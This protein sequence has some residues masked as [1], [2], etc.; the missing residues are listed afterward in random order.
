MSEPS[1]C[2]ASHPDSGITQSS[3]NLPMT[4]P[5]NKFTAPQ[6]TPTTFNSFKD[7]FT[8]TPTKVAKKEKKGKMPDI[9]TTGALEDE[10]RVA[11]LGYKQEVRGFTAPL[12][13]PS[14]QPN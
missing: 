7:I 11:K 3:R 6:F 2:A 14:F 5:K 1:L 13:L 8:P 10:L 4:H 9:V 12:L